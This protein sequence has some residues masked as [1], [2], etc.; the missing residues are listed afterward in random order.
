MKLY[1]SRGA[2]SLSVRINI[3][4][5][6]IQCDYVE[7]DLKNHTLMDGRDYYQINPKGEVPA[8]EIDNQILTENIAIHTYL[9]KTHHATR[10]LPSE[11]DFK[12]FRIL[13]WMSFIS[14]DLHKS[15]GPLFHPIFSVEI[16]ENI[17]IPMLQK[18]FQYVDNCLQDKEYLLDEYCLPDAYMFVMIFWC[19]KL[20][21]DIS[22]LQN[23][24][25]YYQRLLGRESV[26]KALAEEGL[27]AE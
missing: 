13:E 25:N 24:N 9:A 6:G 11:N 2:C 26:K 4:E 23:V 12:F 20:H 14:S 27:Q 5:M 7:V 1:F 22:T 21:V 15:F 18:K 19:H 3:H 10:L 8:L 16:K 17:L